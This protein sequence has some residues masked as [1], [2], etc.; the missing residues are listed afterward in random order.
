MPKFRN[1]A[2]LLILTLSLLGCAEGTKAS[3]YIANL[4]HPGPRANRYKQHTWS[5]SVCEDNKVE[6]IS[7]PTAITCLAKGSEATFHSVKAIC[8]E[9]NVTVTFEDFTNPPFHEITPGSCGL[10]HD[11]RG[12]IFVPSAKPAFSQ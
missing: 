7:D 5:R 2:S 1:F 4:T 12:T 8:D 6:V 9:T 3:A 11:Q 10:F